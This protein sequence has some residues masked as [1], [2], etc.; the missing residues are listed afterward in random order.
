MSR[1]RSLASALLVV[2][3]LGGACG[4]SSGKSASTKAST[5]KVSAKARAD[6]EKKLKGI[7]AEEATRFVGKVEGTE[8]FIGIRKRGDAV[9]AYLCDSKDLAVWMDGKVTGE[10]VAA[11]K[12][13]ASLAGTVAAGGKQIT[14][15]VKLPDGSTHNFSADLA[16]APAGFYEAFAPDLDLTRAGWVVLASG[17]QRGNAKTGTI[18][19]PVAQLSTSTRTAAL[20]GQQVP[21]IPSPGPVP[22]TLSCDDLIYLYTQLTVNLVELTGNGEDTTNVVNSLNEILAVYNNQCIGSTRT[23]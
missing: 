1:I 16:A 12:D 2:A 22:N 7:K 18:V 15:T 6:F 4:G 5:S 20:G 21:V 13:P 23:H 19:K 8:A 10:A 3:V 17:E 11:A 14:G 9:T